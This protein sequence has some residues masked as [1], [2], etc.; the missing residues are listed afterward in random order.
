MTE[1]PWRSLTAGWGRRTPGDKGWHSPRV[2][3]TS[4]SFPKVPTAT[5]PPG[6][7][8][9]AGIPWHRGKNLEEGWGAPSV[10]PKPPELPIPRG[11]QAQR[12]S[13]PLPGH[14]QPCD[15]PKLQHIPCSGTS[16]QPG[17][18]TVAKSYRQ[19]GFVPELL[20]FSLGS[21]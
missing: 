14:S 6:T 11:A 18:R 3:V 4:A 16:L 17:H 12:S 10:T 2:T 13:R 15:V 7:P 19:G 20:R 9:S 1:Q 5:A 8:G 21:G